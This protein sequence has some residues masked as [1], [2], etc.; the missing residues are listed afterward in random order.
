MWIGSVLVALAAVYL[1]PVIAAQGRGS[2]KTWIALMLAGLFGEV[3]SVM[4]AGYL[5]GPIAP[6]LLSGPVRV[7]LARPLTFDLLALIIRVSLGFCLGSLLA[8]VLYRK[9]KA[10][11]PSLLG[12]G[13]T[14]NKQQI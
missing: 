6:V 11:S 12:L 14:I 9:R 5:V 13:S 4:L 3:A 2:R 7:S 10:V 1:P 8:V